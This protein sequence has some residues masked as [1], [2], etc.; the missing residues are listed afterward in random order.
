MSLTKVPFNMIAGAVINILDYGADASGVTDSTTAIDTAI[1]ASINQDKTLYIPSGTFKYTGTGSSLGGS[2][3]MRGDGIGKS[4]ININANGTIFSVTTAID[5]PLI[6][7]GIQFNLVSPLTNTNATLFYTSNGIDFG[8]C[9]Q[10]DQCSF[11]NW[12]NTAI[13][14]IRAFNSSVKD[15]TIQGPNS[16]NATSGYLTGQ[17]AAGLRFWG[18]DGTATVQDHTFSNLCVFERVTVKNV[19]Y[20]FDFWNMNVASITACTFERSYIG[21]MIR[22]NPTPSVA[23]MVSSTEKGGYSY[24][25]CYVESCWF[26]DIYKYYILNYDYDPATDAP[27]NINKKATVTQAS[28]GE[29]NYNNDDAKVLYAASYPPLLLRGGVQFYNV[30]GIGGSTVLHDYEEGSWTPVIVNVT[31]PG[32]D[33]TITY[34][35]QIGKYTKV[36]DTVTVTANI[37]CTTVTGGTPSGTVIINGLPYSPVD[38][39]G[40][41]SFSAMENFDTVY[42]NTNGQTITATSNPGLPY[43]FFS[44]SSAAGYSAWTVDKI[45]PNFTCRMTMTY[46]T[47]AGS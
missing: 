12:T 15:C 26:E 11:Q 34:T 36:G 37:V 18:A 17:T 21:L 43:V 46:R 30:P 44:E 1:V 4:I 3:V 23:G 5:S 10:I 28:G 27:V 8:S 42:A 32:T 35:T 25:L 24:A 19:L 45:L 7:S 41:G 31:T 14:A 13:H 20:G 47:T 22:P 16:Y 40:T 38:V 33:P 39:Y 2:V 6:V 9:V 29:T